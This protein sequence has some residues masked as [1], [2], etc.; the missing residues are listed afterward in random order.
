MAAA[1]RCRAD[2]RHRQDQLRRARLGGGR[3]DG[4]RDAH[5]G[6][7]RRRATPDHR[8]IVAVLRYRSNADWGMLRSLLP[9]VLP[10]LLLG[11]VFIRVVNDLMLRRSIGAILLIS[12]L[13]QL[14][15]TA[16]ANRRW[17]ATTLVH[18]AR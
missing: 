3:A 1:D 10:G 6:I 15:V 16:V 5:Q 9:S 17:P 18:L 13:I 4:A 7:H 8:N 2:H 12:V 14:A 11:A